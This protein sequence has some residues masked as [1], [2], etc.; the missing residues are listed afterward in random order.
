MNEF[1]RMMMQR[2][3]IEE[4][5]SERDFR[6]FCEYLEERDMDEEGDEE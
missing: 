6:E 5:E 1:E 2:D 3:G 4:S